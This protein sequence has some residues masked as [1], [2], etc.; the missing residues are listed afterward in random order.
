MLLSKSN[1]FLLAF[2]SHASLRVIGVVIMWK[3]LCL[4]IGRVKRTFVNQLGKSMRFGGRLPD[5]PLACKIDWLDPL[6]KL[7]LGFHICKMGTQQCLALRVW[8]NVHEIYL[9]HS[10]GASYMLNKGEWLI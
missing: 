9:E 3:L 7:H 4:K 5:S 2:N 6:S 8:V 10:L 1:G